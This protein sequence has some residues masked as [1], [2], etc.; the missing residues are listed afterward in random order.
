MQQQLLAIAKLCDYGVSGLRSDTANSME[1]TLPAD[2]FHPKS[3][4][5]KTTKALRLGLDL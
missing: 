4:K 2:L 1:L 3:Y 5:G